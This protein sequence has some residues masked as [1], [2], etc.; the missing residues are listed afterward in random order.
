MRPQTIAQL[1]AI[2]PP[3]EFLLSFIFLYLV[4]TPNFFLSMFG[5]FFTFPGMVVFYVALYFILYYVFKP[6]SWMPVYIT[7]FFAISYTFYIINYM[8]TY[9]KLTIQSVVTNAVNKAKEDLKNKATSTVT[10][11]LSSSSVK[12]P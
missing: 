11:T 12:L 10:S 3:I 6:D 2:T 9:K 4:D 1:L 7:A 8:V 5:A